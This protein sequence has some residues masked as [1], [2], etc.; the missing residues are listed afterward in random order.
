[1]KK[2]QFIG[3]RGYGPTGNRGVDYPENTLL[4]FSHA[5]EVGADGIELDVFLSKDG[6]PVVI[7]DR[8]LHE[9]VVPT[10]VDLVAGRSVADFTF[11]ELQQFDVGSKDKKIPSLD[12]VFDLF[13][14]HSDKKLILNLDVKEPKSV[15]AILAT[16]NKYKSDK[17]QH[18]VIISSY[19]WDILKDLRKQDAEVKLVPAIKTA[20]L[21]GA[22]NVRESDY[23]PLTN[24]YQENFREPVIALHN[25]IGCYAFDCSITDYTSDMIGFALDYNVGLQFSSGNDRVN[26][27][28]TDYDVLKQLQDSLDLGVPFVIC[29]VD[30]P[31]MVKKRINEI[32]TPV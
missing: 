10:Q 32:Y 21:F 5:I 11:E 27:E 16:L 25:E 6:V 13:A 30:E 1:M 17:F 24:K 14:A 28:N 9:H 3:H 15:P 29:K 8:R 19:K 31:D 26:A 20:M 2:I 7:H 4:A 18:E 23:M 12:E 22:E